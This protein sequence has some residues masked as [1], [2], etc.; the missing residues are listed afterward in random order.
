MNLPILKQRLQS[1]DGFL[2]A[3]SLP[4]ANQTRIKPFADKMRNYCQI[5]IQQINDLEEQYY[6]DARASMDHVMS[7]ISPC[8][9][10]IVSSSP[11]MQG[12]FV[13]KEYVKF[14]FHFHQNLNH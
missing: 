9:S 8:E 7:S 13:H 4:M 14:S 11:E 2:E 1:L 3:I 12:M 10:G 6:Q 5:Q